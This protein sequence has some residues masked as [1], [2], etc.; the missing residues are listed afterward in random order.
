MTVQ[1][2]IPLISGFVGAL[3]GALANAFLRERTDRR[4]SKENLVGEIALFARESLASL[5]EFYQASLPDASSAERWGKLAAA[6]RLM[7]TGSALEIRV[8]REFRNRKIRAAFHQLLNRIDTFKDE[9]VAGQVT[10]EGRLKLGSAWVGHR[11]DRAI[12][13][14]SK[15][16]G[17][18]LRDGARVVFVGFRK[19]TPADKQA[20][21]FEPEAVPWRYNLSLELEDELPEEGL[22]TIRQR[23][24]SRVGGMLC[25]EHGQAPH[26]ALVG[27]S[28]NF[29][30]D[31]S[32]C[33]APFISRVQRR[34][35]GLPD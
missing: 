11:A 8:F 7:G 13:L 31:I 21:S 4:T 2:W 23:S 26:I 5:L 16:A 18:P 15:A 28:S 32:A 30:I 19:V 25:P 6:E 12:E 22:Q 1:T 34:F 9:M 33:C 10:D 24:E 27:P 17:I 29:R 20:L 3:F 35:V 14:A